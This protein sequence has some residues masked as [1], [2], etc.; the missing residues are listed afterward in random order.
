MPKRNKRSVFGEDDSGSDTGGGDEGFKKYLEERSLQSKKVARTASAASHLVDSYD[1]DANKQNASIPSTHTSGR[2]GEEAE[3]K[4]SYIHNLLESK[5]QRDLDRLH[6][7]SVKIRLERDLETSAATKE[8]LF[9]TQSYKDKK[10][11]YERADKLA[12]DELLQENEQI[13]GNPLTHSAP[14]VALQFLISEEGKEKKDAEKFQA[15]NDEPKFIAEPNT[16]KVEN[17][18]FIRKPL[19]SF[20]SSCP[21][22]AELKDPLDLDPALKERCIREFL[23]S[24]KTF[25]DI[26]LL[27]EQYKDRHTNAN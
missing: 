19:E 16:K 10:N 24:T 5:K 14:S 17:D 15:D 11:Q 27:A 26:E 22:F 1:R 2:S 7:Q 13:E 9:Y 3:R 18:V 25:Q 12:E 21:K 20:N 8:E 6:S 4:S 23:R